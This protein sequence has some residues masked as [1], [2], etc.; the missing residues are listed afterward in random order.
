MESL[1]I[2]NQTFKIANTCGTLDTKELASHI[3]L[4]FTGLI[5]VDI[6]NK[7]DI[8]FNI[9]KYEMAFSEGS[10]ELEGDTIPIDSFIRITIVQVSIVP[11]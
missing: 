7:F 3:G 9:N 10:I 4:D 2:C 8:L 1:T 11:T 6:L 5:G